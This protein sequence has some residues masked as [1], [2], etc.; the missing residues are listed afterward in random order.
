MY[1]KSTVESQKCWFKK[2]QNIKYKKHFRISVEHSG[3]FWIILESRER[4]S[5][6]SQSNAFWRVLCAVSSVRSQETRP[7]KRISDFRQKSRRAPRLK[8]QN[9]AEPC[10]WS[11]TAARAQTSE[12]GREPRFAWLCGDKT[13]NLRDTCWTWGFLRSPASL[14]SLVQKGLDFISLA[15]EETIFIKL[16]LITVIWNKCGGNRLKFPGNCHWPPSPRHYSDSNFPCCI[17]LIKR[18]I[19]LCQSAWWPQ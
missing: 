2:K 9:K 17:A 10:R 15:A 7:G 1:K 6:R 18:A 4:V 19:Y 14:C 12:S 8:R 5:A 3:I 13:T 16:Y 11:M